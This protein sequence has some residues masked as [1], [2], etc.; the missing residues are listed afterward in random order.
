[1]TVK[2]T[3]PLAKDNQVAR[4]DSEIADIESSIG[5]H[6]NRKIAINFARV[7]PS[8]NLTMASLNAPVMKGR[9]FLEE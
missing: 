1:M 4:R 9:T 7:T 6:T 8:R 3:P 5:M 2:K